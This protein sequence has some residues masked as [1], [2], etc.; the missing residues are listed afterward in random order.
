MFAASPCSLVLAT[1]L[2]SWE[3]ILILSLFL[4]LFGAKKLPGIMRGM[5]TGLSEFR[6]ALD[7]EAQDAGRSAGGIFGKPAAEALTPDNQTGELYN[8]A[9]F[10]RHRKRRSVRSLLRE[11]LQ[12]LLRLLRVR[13]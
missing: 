4:L 6:K 11:L 13:K 3:V 1:S 5:G 9:V 12:G 10:H 2:G 7:Q 8:P